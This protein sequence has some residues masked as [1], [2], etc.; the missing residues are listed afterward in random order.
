LLELDKTVY[1]ANVGANTVTLKVTDINKCA[2]KTATVT[3]E[4]KVAPVGY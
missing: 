1:V 2:T 4:D 3:V